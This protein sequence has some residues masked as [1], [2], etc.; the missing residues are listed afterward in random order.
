VTELTE[1]QRIAIGRALD[2]VVLGGAPI[3][4]CRWLPDDIVA[5]LIEDHCSRVFCG[6]AAEV[7]FRRFVELARAAIRRLDL[8][9]SEVARQRATAPPWP[10]GSGDPL[11]DIRAACCR[12]IEKREGIDVISPELRRKLGG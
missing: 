5:V 4:V 9:P 10:E 6:L 7:P 3:V 2:A 1:K 12:S 8:D 11:D